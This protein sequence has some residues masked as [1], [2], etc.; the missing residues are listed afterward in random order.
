VA[1]ERGS[2]ELAL[3]HLHEV[4]AGRHRGLDG[5]REVAPGRSPVGDE[6][7]TGARKAQKLASPSSGLD[8][9]A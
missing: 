1:E 2:P 6:A 9:L 3:A 8:A 5:R 4:D 7:E